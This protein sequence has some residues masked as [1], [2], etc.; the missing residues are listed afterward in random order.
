MTL[1]LNLCKI[2]IFSDVHFW[3]I[4][5]P[6]LRRWFR[7]GDRGPEPAPWLPW[8]L[9]SPGAALPARSHL[10]GDLVPWS[11]DPGCCAAQKLPIRWSTAGQPVRVPALRCAG[12]WWR[13]PYVLR[14]EGETVQAG[15]GTSGAPLLPAPSSPAPSLLLFYSYRR[16]AASRLTLSSGARFSSTVLSWP[17]AI[18]VSGLQTVPRLR[19]PR[20]VL[21]GLHGLQ[22]PGA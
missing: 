11:W 4:T 9:C 16:R 2:F 3:K 18:S 14:G 20:A 22:R 1:F 17:P 6:G 21:T 5:L 12:L 7:S 8:D 19:G 10:P 15:T 13:G